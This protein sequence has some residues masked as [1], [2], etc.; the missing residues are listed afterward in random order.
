MWEIYPAFSKPQWVRASSTKT[1]CDKFESWKKKF[2][3]ISFLGFFSTELPEDF[4]TEI[5]LIAVFENVSE[6]KGIKKSLSCIYCR[7]EDPHGSICMSAFR[8]LSEVS[9]RQTNPML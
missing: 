5:E 8:K 7:K 2:F 9:E 4:I 6:I 3:S 1:D